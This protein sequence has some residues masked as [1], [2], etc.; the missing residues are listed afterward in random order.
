MNK[1]IVLDGIDG[2]GKTSL[3]TLLMEWLKINTKIK[4]YRT[5]EPFDRKI[6]QRLKTTQFTP[7]HQLDLLLEDR[8]EH[9]QYTIR[10]MI[11]CGFWVFC[12][13]YSASTLAYQGYGHGLDIPRIER[14][15]R[16]ATEGLKPDMTI[17]LDCLV[18]NAIK[19]KI[20]P[21]DY[22][23]VD[24]PFLERVR[25]GYLELAGQH[26]WSV[27]DANQPQEQVFEEVKKLVLPLVPEEEQEGIK[28]KI[29]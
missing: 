18:E 12:D 6:R 3:L 2:S 4:L 9:C 15:D 25:L 22:M 23:E 24:R 13:R 19:R 11:D 8:R 29:F 16:E 5:E 28:A 20:E 27:I 7:V 17:I 10:P 1:F 14:L 21:L 26:S